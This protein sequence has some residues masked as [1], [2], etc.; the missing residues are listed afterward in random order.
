[1]TAPARISDADFQRAAR[2]ATKA[3]MHCGQ[4]VRTIFRLEP[5]EIEIIVGESGEVVPPDHS[6]WSDDDV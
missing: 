4:P 3:F 6:D 5:R 2:A 1:V